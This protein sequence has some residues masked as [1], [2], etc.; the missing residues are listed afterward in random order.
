MKK[1]I[2]KRIIN[3][4]FVSFFYNIKFIIFNI[5]YSVFYNKPKILKCF[6]TMDCLRSKEP[7]NWDGM[8]LLLFLSTPILIALLNGP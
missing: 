6:Y 2:E 8:G 3:K 5:C 7:N 1:R 4:I